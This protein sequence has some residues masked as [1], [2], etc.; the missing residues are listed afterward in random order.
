MRL[1]RRIKD[2]VE[3]TAQVV[4]IT[5]H[6]GNASWQNARIT[7]VVQA[8]GVEPFTLEHRCMVRA[9][10]W[11]SPGTTLPVVFDREHHDRLDVQWDAVPTGR[12]T[13]LEQAEQLRGA[14]GGGDAPTLAG[15]PHVR[16][17]TRVVDLRDQPGARDALLGALEQAT[18]QDLDGDGKVAGGAPPAT[19]DDRLGRLER[20]AAL[21]AQGALSDEEFA[22]EKRRLLG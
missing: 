7:M 10:R 19:G 18:G 5:Q 16:V 6:T 8:L 2:P 3:G 1:L 15:D 4:S 12:E 14:L 9:D 21:H 17:E 22:A 13:A 20:L 11:P